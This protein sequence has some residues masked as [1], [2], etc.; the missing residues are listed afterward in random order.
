MEGID[1]H[2]K[3]QSKQIQKLREIQKQNA[4]FMEGN[5]GKNIK[6]IHLYHDEILLEIDNTQKRISEVLK[7]K[8]DKILETF[9]EKISEIKD[10]LRKEQ[11]K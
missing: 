8:R 4:I 1:I 5:C 7:F 2:D 11:E 6:E 10:Q 3:V 9:D